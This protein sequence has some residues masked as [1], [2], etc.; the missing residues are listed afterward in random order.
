M[1]IQIKNGRV[2]DPA[3]GVDA[4]QDVFIAAGKILAIGAAPADFIANK[5]WM[6]AGLLWRRGWWI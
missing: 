1:K 5:S 4:V 6:P 3:S 2:I